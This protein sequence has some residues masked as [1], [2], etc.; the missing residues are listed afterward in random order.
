M[1]TGRRESS[2]QKWQHLVQKVTELSVLRDFSADYLMDM[3]GSI[4]GGAPVREGTA[5]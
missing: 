4:S 1:P 3:S 2:H 5:Q